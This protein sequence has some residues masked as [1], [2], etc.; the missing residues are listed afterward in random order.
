MECT[1]LTTI[2]PPAGPWLPS[3]SPFVN[4][5]R[6]E[7]LGQSNDCPSYAHT[8]SVILPPLTTGTEAPGGGRQTLTLS[9]G[10][11]GGGGGVTSH[12]KVELWKTD[13]FDSLGTS[14]TVWVSLYPRPPFPDTRFPT[15][16]KGEGADLP[17][18]RE[19]N[20]TN[21]SYSHWGR[22]PG[23]IGSRQ[24]ELKNMCF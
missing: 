12:W 10:H 7:S 2:L 11:C 14:D 3:I 6:D 19:A 18:L 23:K 4:G 8:L 13:H 17:S 5:H 16:P 21:I 9:A 22:R 24:K 20:Q 1:N 15:P